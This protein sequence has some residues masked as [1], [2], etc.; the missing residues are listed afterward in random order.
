M[1]ELQ[2]RDT[3]GRTFTPARVAAGG[4][5]LLAALLVALVMLGGGDPGY[6][7]KAQF[8][9]AGQLVKGN[10]VEVAGVKAGTVSGFEITPDGLAEVE[11]SIDDRYAPLRRGTRVVIRQGSQ[12]SV[13][14]RYVDLHLP[15]ENEAGPP[16]EDGATLGQES[17]TTSV[18]FDQFLNIFDRRTRRGLSGFYKGGH[19]QYAGA[20]EA[21]NRSLP[22]F[23]PQLGAASRL[24]RELNRDEPALERFL[25]GSSKFVTALADRDEDLAAVVESLNRT[26][27]ALAADK[28]AL[29][30]VIERLPGFM[31]SANTTYVTLR[32]TL[33]ELDPFVEASKPVARKLGPVLDELRPFAREARGTVSDLADLARRPG[34]DNDLLEL[35]RTYPPLA[36]IAL[37]TKVRNG[38]PRRG[39]FP[40][41]AQA[42][43][44]TAPI[45]AHGRPYTVDLLG[46]FDDFSHTG[47]YDAL[48]G[49]SRVQTYFNAFTISNTSTTPIPLEQQG[50]VFRQL[51]KIEQFK[52][53]PGGG[54]AR[55]K[56]GS[57]V[58][59]E[60]EQ[61]ELDC[62][63]AHRAVGPK[64]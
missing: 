55:A 4:A 2:G 8:L 58:L 3:T 49:F 54:E 20:G 62:V 57:N 6:K 16:F 60:Q 39:A 64:Q 15:P 23:A 50:T 40:E 38:E 19:R 56:D 43:R 51:A 30:E 41:L 28:A 14:N 44:D 29:S 1:S 17:T 37:D 34:P 63:E 24:F 27:R 53:C 48:G 12:S 59:T 31:R 11:L 22:Y 33:D 7:V 52:R 42:F 32:G 35:N 45:T 25:V 47:A 10:L 13:A 21:A 5:V 18:D 46:W 61:A 9:N 26:T 36:E